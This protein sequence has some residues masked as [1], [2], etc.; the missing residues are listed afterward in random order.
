MA[1]R[2][3][4]P[5]RP[6]HVVVIG[7]GFGGLATVRGLCNT[8]VRVTWIDRKNY[9]LFQP[10]LYQVATAALS[11]ADIAAPARGI[12]RTWRN[13]ETVLAEVTG[14][15]AE[16]RVVKTTRQTY[17]YEYL[18]MATGAETSYFGNE[19]WARFADGLKT[20]EE[21]V[22]IRRKVLLSL[23]LAETAQSEEERRRLLTF[24]LIGAGP[25]GVEMAGAIADLAKHMLA[26]D[27]RHIESGTICVILLEA[28][29]QV[30]P[31]YPRDLAT[32]AEKKLKEMGVDVRTG[33]KVED[34]DEEG[35]VAGGTRIA[36][37]TIIWS[38]GVK[39]TPIA[40]W[41]GTEADKKG[42]VKVRPDLSLP[43]R[44]EVFVIG[45][46]ALA[47]D[48]EGHPLPGLAAVAKQQGAYVAR[49]LLDR[50]KGR[51]PLSPFCYHDWGTLATMGKASAV[52]NFGRLRLR[53]FVAW[54]VWVLVHIWY[55]IGFRNRVRVLLNWVWLYATFSP[56]ARLITGDFNWSEL[57]VRESS[58][59][60]AR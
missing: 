55:L 49:C 7:A 24:V 3:T 50:I 14:I 37:R 4:Q 25:T 31:G 5:G 6:P 11:P 8:P 15:D 40:D 21:A 43:S 44:P 59:A 52:A 16:A 45:D 33:T 2:A 57:G 35:V 22:A 19:K 56:G 1:T 54:V 18:V 47:L 10:L 58:E 12:A 28:M 53:G 23:E 38:A 48:E 36:S 34:I 60:K 13:V 39:A 17:S 32:F 41:L 51:E 9:H 20:L 46:A 27:F 26:R 29:D 30:L 42:L